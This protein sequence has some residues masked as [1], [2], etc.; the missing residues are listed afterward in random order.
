MHQIT[1]KADKTDIF[2]I[3]TEPLN[4]QCPYTGSAEQRW[5]FLAKI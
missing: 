1:F 2:N 5:N 4:L 3:V